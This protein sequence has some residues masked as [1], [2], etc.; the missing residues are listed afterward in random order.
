[1]NNLKKIPNHWKWV[2]LDDI[3]LIVSGGTPSTKEPE[4]WNGDIPWITPSDLSGYEEVFV[5]KGSRNISQVG[6]DYSAAYLLPKNSIVFSSRAPIGYV[7][8]TKNELATNQ[9]FKNLILPSNSVNPKYVYYYLKTVKELAENMASGTTFLELS[10]TKFKQ[11][12]FPLA[13]IEEQNRITERIEELFSQ[14]DKSI[15]DIDNTLELIELQG[16]NILH[17]TFKNID[18]TIVRLE[19]ITLKITDGT[20]YT[21]KYTKSGIH[22]ISVKDIREGKIDF[23]NTKFI[24]EEE[25]KNFVKRC[26]PEYGD[27]LI[28]KSGT[29]GRLA[30]VPKT[31]EFSLFVSVALIK[32][33]NKKINNKFLFYYLEYFISTLNVKEDIKGAVQKNF[34]LEDIRE[35]NVPLVELSE[36]IQISEYIEQQINSL[37]ELKKE[38][39]SSKKTKE[40]LFF[41]I[42]QEAFLA[43]LTNQQNTDT[44]IEVLLKNIIKE[45]EKYLLKQQ[46]II[47]NRPKIKK[48]EKE[49]L[50]IIQVLEKNKNP[51][52]PKQLWEDSMYKDNIENFYS[53]LKK[54]YDK[55]IEEKTEKGSLISLK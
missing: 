48:M 33:D 52:S 10:A 14:L 5:S 41:K 17:K 47:K 25:H 31:P 7:A 18:A 23:T 50:T 37:N 4:F 11:I 20:H 1:M 27:I 15:E 9:G 19:D 38:A 34:H 3:G 36:Q 26:N 12:P 8:I 40:K 43:K 39:I 53:E 13:P 28:T 51:I 30:I 46:E 2:T 55:I 49:K 24:S 29:I 44:P 32:I 54:V 42:L 45:K 22:F 21:P 6:L 16:K 35:V